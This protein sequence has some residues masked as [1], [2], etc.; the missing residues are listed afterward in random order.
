MRII[1]YRHLLRSTKFCNLKLR[2]TQLKSLLYV[3]FKAKMPPPLL[4]VTT[5]TPDPSSSKSG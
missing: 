5:D 2:I 3:R 1:S 4:S